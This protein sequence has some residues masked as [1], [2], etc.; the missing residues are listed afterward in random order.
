MEREEKKVRIINMFHNHPPALQ[1]VAALKAS[2]DLVST[3]KK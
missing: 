2:M 3:Q 1:Q